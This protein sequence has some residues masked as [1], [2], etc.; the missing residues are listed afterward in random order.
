MARHICPGKSGS[1]HRAVLVRSARAE[2]K[3]SDSPSWEMGMS[4]QREFRATRKELGGTCV[5][6]APLPESVC[7]QSRLLRARK[8]N[9]PPGRAAQRGLRLSV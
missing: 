2:W 1:R 5:P 9:L 7:S 6:V 8:T 4:V 3:G